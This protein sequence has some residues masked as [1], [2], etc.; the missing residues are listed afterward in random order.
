MFSFHFKH[1]LHSKYKISRTLDISY[2]SIHL[3]FM[4]HNSEHCRDDKVCWTQSSISHPQFFHHCFIFG[5]FVKLGIFLIEF[6]GHVAFGCSSV[7]KHV[8]ACQMVDCSTAAHCFK[9]AEVAQAAS[10][11]NS[12]KQSCSFTQYM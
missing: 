7:Q 12:F 11:T 1:I 10:A 6:S 8:K 5:Q 2:Q 9:K 4:S 3:K